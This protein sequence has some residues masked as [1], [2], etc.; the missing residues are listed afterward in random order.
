MLIYRTALIL[1]MFLYSSSWY[2]N[3]NNTSYLELQ[4]VHQFRQDRVEHRAWVRRNATDNYPC[5][6]DDDF[7]NDDV[8]GSGDSLR[9]NGEHSVVDSTRHQ[10]AKWNNEFV[11]VQ[12]TECAF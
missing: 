5:G 8:T 10:L 2:S 1:L 7:R 3:C 12:P 4:C 9:L 11:G 6:Y